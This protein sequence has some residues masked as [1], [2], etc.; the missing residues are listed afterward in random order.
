[1]AKNS[2]LH[3]ML[4][5]MLTLEAGG[6]ASAKKHNEWE[7]MDYS[8]VRARVRENDTGYTTPSITGCMDDDLYNCL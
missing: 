4:V 1:M 7:D 3:I 5:C 6:C 8:R 2:I